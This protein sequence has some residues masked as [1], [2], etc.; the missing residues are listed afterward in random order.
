[1]RRTAHAARLPLLV[2]VNYYE[3]WAH[4]EDP[5]VGNQY[6]F[7]SYTYRV[8]RRPGRLLGAV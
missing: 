8:V 4:L 1:M 2:D 5:P 6:T 7:V 3:N